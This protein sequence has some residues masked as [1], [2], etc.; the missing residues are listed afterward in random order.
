MLYPQQNDCRNKLDVSGNDTLLYWEND[1]RTR[2][3]ALYLESFG[4]PAKFARHAARIARSKPIVALKA[5]R[6]A[7]GGTQRRRRGS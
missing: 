1:P 3:I 7:A 4:N 5:G 6:T 2:V